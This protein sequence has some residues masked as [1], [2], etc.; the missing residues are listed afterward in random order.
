MLSINN[1]RSMES[2]LQTEI[3]RPDRAGN[4]WAP[5]PHFDVVNGLA[6]EMDHRGWKF[7][8][9]RCQLL[10]DDQNMVAEFPGLKIPGQEAPNGQDFRLVVRNSHNQSFA[11]SVSVASTVLVCT[12]GLTLSQE[13]IALCRKHTTGFSLSDGIDKALNDYVTG[14]T[15]IGHM[16]KALEQIYCDDQRVVD[17][18][19]LAAGR[20]GLM[21]WSHIGLVDDEYKAPRHPEFKGRNGWSLYNCFTEVLKKSPVI[22]QVDS[23]RKLAQVIFDAPAAVNG[24]RTH[25]LA[26]V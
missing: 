24:Q 3:K 18:V 23:G 20:S 13:E 17:N 25:G 21:P 4:R 1:P 15:K 11:L 12:N 14:A 26:A 10:A 9:P 16:T 8:S 22:R 5:V 7:D 19:L 2:L 6:V